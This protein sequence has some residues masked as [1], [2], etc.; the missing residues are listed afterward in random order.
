[1]SNIANR[2]TPAMGV[3]GP[4]NRLYYGDNL[5]VLRRKIKD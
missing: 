1:M 5:E 4:N 2:N 3:N